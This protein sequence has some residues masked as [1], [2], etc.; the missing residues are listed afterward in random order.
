MR[1]TAQATKTASHSLLGCPIT[2]A[3][4]A[5]LAVVDC[6]VGSF[7]GPPWSCDQDLLY[8]VSVASAMVTAALSIVKGFH[9]Q[10]QHSVA[11][12]GNGWASTMS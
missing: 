11:F 9:Y 8:R 10:L 3:S 5:G 1:A 7:G 6:W 12:L 4:F 2:G